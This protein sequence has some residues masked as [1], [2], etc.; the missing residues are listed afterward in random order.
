MPKD[1]LYR[2]LL[3]RESGVEQRRLVAGDRTD[4]EKAAVKAA[5][6][7]LKE[8]ILPRLKTE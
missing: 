2:R 3:S 7:R 5:S 1:S 8:V 6:G 4:D